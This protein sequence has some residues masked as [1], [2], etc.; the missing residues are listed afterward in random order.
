MG[1][2]STG[3]IENNPVNGV[4]PSQL[5]T[6]KVDNR[7]SANSSVVLIRFNRRIYIGWNQN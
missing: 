1:I 6:V 5:V 7:D 4:R 3:P 2:L